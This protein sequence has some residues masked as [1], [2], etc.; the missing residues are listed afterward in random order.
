MSSFYIC[1]SY[2]QFFSKN[3]CELDIVLT[4]TVNILTTNELIKLTML[5]TTGT[6]TFGLK[7]K[8]LI[9]S[10]DRPWA[11]HIDVQADLDLHW[12]QGHFLYGAAHI[13]G[14]SKNVS[15]AVRNIQILF[16]VTLGFLLSA[17]TFYSIQWFRN[18][19][20][21]VMIRLSSLDTKI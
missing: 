2:S 17:D 5:W 14:Y 16:L 3:T 11:D 7:K 6:C 21:K 12:S 20:V 18:W 9:K 8:H 13:F 10:Y 4:R 1:K 19:T 15:E